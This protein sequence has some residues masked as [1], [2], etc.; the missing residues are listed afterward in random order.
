[1]ARPILHS[2]TSFDLMRTSGELASS[3]LDYI[4]SY[5]VEG[6]STEILNELCHNFIIFNKAIPAPLNYHGFPKSICTSVNYIVCHGIPSVSKSLKKGDIINIDVT[7]IID[8]WH[9]DTSRMFTIGIIHKQARLLI[10]VTYTCMVLG[11]SVVRPG[12]STSDIGN[13]IQSYADNMGFTVVRDFCGHGIG[14]DF[15]SAPEILHFGNNDS[16]G[17]ILEEGMFFTIEPMINI[18]THNVKV[19]RDGWTV[20]T[21]DKK[22]SSQFEHTLA[23][24]KNGSEV[25]TLTC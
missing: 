19:L 16:R 8:G 2:V 17:V 1:M 9:G 10:D 21:K 3:T 25:F 6:I 18:G 22:L 24:T 12:N 13:I 23:V 5:V 14:E 4:S 11:I 20:V 7:V 15:H